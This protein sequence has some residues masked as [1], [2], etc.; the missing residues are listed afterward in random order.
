MSE[1]G[2]QGRRR[3]SGRT[4]SL[5]WS[6]RRAS[7][8]RAPRFACIDRALGDSVA[9]LHA[10]LLEPTETAQA[11]AHLAACHACAADARVFGALDRALASLTPEEAEVAS[12]EPA[13]DRGR[14]GRARLIPSTGVLLAVATL[15]VAFALLVS[16]Q[17]TR[18]RALLSEV[19]TLRE[20]VARV[21]RRDLAADAAAADEA[22]ERRP[23]V[24]IVGARFA[25]PPNF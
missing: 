21:E 7:G 22:T 3:A 9:L 6:R 14:S 4:W 15:V 19:Y 2:F 25:S 18:D 10:G 23:V 13:I 16:W 8:G 24:P 17:R 20:R 1:R 12:L 11:E 5:G